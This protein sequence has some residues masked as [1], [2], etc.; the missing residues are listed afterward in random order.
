MFAVDIERE[1]ALSF[2]T[3]ELL[4]SGTYDAAH[5]GH[6]HFDVSLEGERFLMV[7]HGVAAGPTEVRVILNWLRE[8]PETT[9]EMRE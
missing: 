4:F 7:K 2:G 9:S 5:I 1:P 8:L 6:Q 3:P